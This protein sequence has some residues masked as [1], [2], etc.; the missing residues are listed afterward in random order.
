MDFVNQAYAQLSE[1]MRSMSVGTRVATGLLLVLVVVSVAYLLQYQVTGGDEL[2]LGGRSFDVSELTQMEAAFAKANLGKWQTV[3]NQIRVPRGQKELYMAA[4]ADA[5]DEHFFGHL[6][7]S[8]RAGLVRTLRA[9]ADHHHLT[10][11]PVD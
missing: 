3:G 7:P 8:A 9:L 1:L 11:F 10:A 6:S 4:L 2:L 5:N